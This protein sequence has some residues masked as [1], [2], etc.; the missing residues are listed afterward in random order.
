MKNQ[1]A[2]QLWIPLLLAD[3]SPCLRMLVLRELME[4][5][6]DDP[7]VVELDKLRT[8]DQLV[9]D[10]L[11]LQESDG[12]WRRLGPISGSTSIQ[13][14]AQALLRLGFLG[15]GPDFP[16]VRQGAEY[17]FSL[18][19]PDGAWPMPGEIEEGERYS[20]Y[21]MVPLQTA[22]PLRGLAACG[23]ATE[24]QAEK[25]YD[26]LL[27][28][29]LPDGA[30]PSG[31]ADGTYGRVA[32][33]RRLPH[34]RWGCRSNT[35]GVLLCLALHPQRK[36]SSEAHRALDL[37]LARESKD[38]HNLGHEIARIV[39]LEPASGFFTYYARFDLAMI[40]ALC[41]Q[42]GASIE[43]T[44]VANM[45]TF[46]IGQQGPYGL[47]EYAP[48]PQA[49]RWI[50]FDLLRSLS[51]LDWHSDWFSM[52]PRTPFQTYASRQRRY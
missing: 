7:E 36:R 4:R 30:W 11:K 31:L 34:S 49:T 44:R 24:P 40:L 18:Q 12:S 6:E 38:R 50:T 1:P 26:W 42:V 32:G 37:L 29:R 51:R 22:I 15:F 25:A 48:G 27:E 47:W 10:L 46:V 13:A 52:E 2:N 39:G 3:A 16:A 9:A 14:T 35:T 45:I 41:W 17:L 21:S 28:Q 8:N 43:D 23:F 5:P 20:H 33:Y 19:R